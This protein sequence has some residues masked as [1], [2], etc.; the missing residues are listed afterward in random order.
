M[1]IVVCH[2]PVKNVEHKGTEDDLRK[3]WREKHH[4]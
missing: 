4:N 2:D 3:T 1:L